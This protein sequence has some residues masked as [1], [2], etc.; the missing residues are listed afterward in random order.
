MIGTKIKICGL[1][2]EREIDFANRLRPDWIGFV[3]APQSRRFVPPR[4]AAELRARLSPDITPVGV[5]V[6]EPVEHVAALLHQGVIG[7]AQLHGGE[8]EAY[9]SALRRLTDKPILQ[10][11]GVESREDVKRAARSAADYILLDHGAGG[12]GETFDWTLL[13]EVGRPFFLAGGLDA[14]NVAAAIRRTHP[15]AVDTSSGVETGHKKDLQKMQKFISLVRGHGSGI[16][17]PVH[18]GT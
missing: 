18:G 12:T 3:F 4:R 10:A 16:H 1:R 14:D 2:E 15:Y 8:N 17:G 11:F 6:N 5:F 7:M 9:L 13:R